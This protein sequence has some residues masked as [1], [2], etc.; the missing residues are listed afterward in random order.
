MDR[1]RYQKIR[2]I[3]LRA[4]EVREKD[5][6]DFLLRECASD[7][8]LL[9]DVREYLARQSVSTA[10]FGAPPVP[11]EFSLGNDSPYRILERIG[12]G[13]FGE[14]YIADQLRPVRRRVAIKVL[15]RGMDSKGVLARFNAERQTLAIMDHPAIA[16]IHDAGV[17]SDGRSYFVMEYVPGES[18]VDFCDRLKLSTH[19]RL[20]LFIT[21]CRG[22]QHAH[23]RGIIHRDLKPANILVSAVDQ[24]YHL[25]II[26][27][28]IAKATQGVL[29]EGTLYTMKGQLI[30][31]PEYMSPEQARGDALDIDTRSDIYSLGTLLYVLLTGRLPIRSDELRGAGL[32]EVPR[33][34]SEV[35]PPRPSVLFRRSDEDVTAIAR[36][37][38]TT[39][40]QLAR[41]LRGDLEWITL[42]ALE[43]DRQRRYGTANEF[44]A[45]I[46]RY[47]DNEP[48]SAG[49]PGA[50]YR[51]GKFVRRNR[52]G[53]VAGTLVA[54]ALVVAVA[55]L[56]VGFLRAQRAEQAARRDQQT[57]EEALSFITGLF[58]LSDPSESRGNTVTAREI[59]DRGAKEVEQ[60]LAG[61]PAVQARLMHFMGDVYRKLGLYDEAAP[62][63]EKTLALRKETLSP[64]DSELAFTH[65]TLAINLAQ[66]DRFSEAS[67]HITEA[68]RIYRAEDPASLAYAR[69]L[70]NHALIVSDAGNFTRSDTLFRQATALYATHLPETDPEFAQLRFNHAECL[71]RLGRLEAA[72]DMLLDVIE[73]YE[74]ARD[75]THPSLMGPLSSL[76]FVYRDLGER[77]KARAYYERAHAVALEAF[78]EGH[79]N[80]ASTLTN[81]GTLALDGGDHSRADSLFE[82]AAGIYERAIGPMSNHLLIPLNQMANIRVSMGRYEE[83]LAYYD[84]TLAISERVYG[85]EAPPFASALNG[86]AE[87]YRLRG[88]YASATP[89][90]ERATRIWSD[91]LGP[92]HPN[93]TIGIHN[94]ACVKR[95]SGEWETADSLFQVSQRNFDAALGEAHPFV[96][97]NLEE[98]AALYEKMGRSDRAAALRERARRIG[99]ALQAQ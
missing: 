79:L 5:R 21:V 51:V 29:T 89:L 46:Q 16:K 20:S 66:S 85:S 63:L 80:T 43:K 10:A 25:K 71:R 87:V 9:Q 73:V 13:G 96:K 84:R 75:A 53:V 50:S 17:S 62:L 44:A 61:E 56:A 24:E 97:A 81:L 37:R 42:K 15:K 54:A 88:D 22:V 86:V 90:Y 2:E 52:A 55:G 7:A 93:T 94:L 27:F 12:E 6:D 64:E 14:V 32:A 99:E 23:Q 33:I 91:A 4:S 77:A 92:E 3:V 59:L 82:R 65:M 58:E 39:P 41:L 57:T 19:E 74:S 70:N 76:G 47:L 30:G 31:T 18:I 28:G 38:K 49:P 72:R 8:G 95:D 40:G 1:K 45:D 35:E 78:G 26:D 67:T 34:L 48:V 83:A 98:H 68:I 11:G 36:N 60:E 69:C